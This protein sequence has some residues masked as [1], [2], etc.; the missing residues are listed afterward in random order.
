MHWWRRVG[1]SMVVAAL[2]TAGAG[3]LAVAAGSPVVI[4]TLADENSIASNFG[5]DAASTYGQTVT[6]PEVAAPGSPVVL[7][8]FTFR[9]DLPAGLVFRGFVY[10]WDG[11]KATGP[12]LF[13]SPAVH[14]SGAGME[15]VTFATPEIPVVAGQQYVI[16]ASIALDLAIDVG[17]GQGPWGIASPSTYADGTF[18]YL[19]T[20]TDSSQWTTTDWSQFIFVTADAAFSATFDSP[21]V[22]P[23]AAPVEVTPRFTG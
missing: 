14:T 15:S 11:T 1:T 22:A 9:M 12:E 18:V 2:V 17:K 4:S 20:G 13:Q 21:T 5:D 16:F 3:S 7:T 8:S 23:S 19:G 10:A 6:A